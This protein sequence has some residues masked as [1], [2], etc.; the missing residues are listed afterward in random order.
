MRDTRA[1]EEAQAARP[2]PVMACV[3]AQHLA[4]GIDADHAIELEVERRCP[5]VLH[6]RVVLID[7]SASSAG[8]FRGNGAVLHIYRESEK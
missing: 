6:A 5:E 1:A 2:D 7:L 8:D 3:G 4:V